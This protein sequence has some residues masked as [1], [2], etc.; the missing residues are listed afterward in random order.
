VNADDGIHWQPRICYLHPNK[1]RMKLHRLLPLLFALTVLLPSLAKAQLTP[2]VDSIAMRDGKLIA[3]DIHLPSG[4]GPWPVILIQTPYNRLLYRFGLPLGTGLDIASSNYAFVITDW[5]GFYGSSGAAVPGADRGQDGYDIVEWITAQSWSNGK[6][7]TWGPSALGKIQFMTAKYNPPG[8]VCAVPLV[9]SMQTQYQEYYPGGAL[10]KEYL[11]QLDV[12]GYGLSAVVLP[13][14]TEDFYWSFATNNSSYHDSIRIPMLMI[15]GWYDHNIRL[16]MEDFD[17]LLTNSD[18]SVRDQHKLLMGPWAHGGS[19]TASVGDITQGQLDYPE[20]ERWNDTFALR[21]LNYYLLGTPNSWDTTSTITYFE[22]GANT[23]HADASFPPTGTTYE[24]LYLHSAGQLLPTLPVAAS[25]SLT[26]SYDPNDPSPTVGGTTLRTDLD[27]GPYDQA[28]IVESRGDVM[29][30][31]SDVLANDVMVAGPPYAEIYVSSD[32]VDTDV[33]V[34]LTDVYPDGRSMLVHDGVRRMRFRSNFT[35]PTLMTPGNIYLATVEMPHTCI[36]FQAGHRIRLDVTFSNYPRFDANDNSG[37]T[38]YV[39]GDTFVA[40]NTVYFQATEASKLVLPTMLMTGISRPTT[41]SSL[42]IWP[43]PAM[44]ILT[45]RCPSPMESWQ[46]VDLQGRVVH[47]IA[48]EKEGELFRLRISDLAQGIYLL[49]V[50][51]PQGRESI[52]FVKQD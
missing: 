10:R 27:Q 37:G 22:M 36:T 28:P 18:V 12:L 21:F 50:S 26:R 20:A 47:G 8:L 44:E 40:A 31:S 1:L 15:G 38:M 39:P 19:G 9:A 11:D 30:F 5:R 16:M 6:V 29:I 23:W 41:S 24:S 46:V 33:C 52:R 4:S 34:R 48:S 51:T 45:V 7:G 49:Q 32:Q 25:A 14:P 42:E 13:H 43:N 35:S 3:A 17:L 2:T